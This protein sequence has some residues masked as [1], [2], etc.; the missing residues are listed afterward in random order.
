[1]HFEEVLERLGKECVALGRRRHPELGPAAAW[2]GWVTLRESY[3]LAVVPLDLAQRAIV[4]AELELQVRECAAWLW[5]ERK[6]RGLAH[7]MCLFLL[8]E[9]ERA[10]DLEAAKYYRHNV[11][12][13]L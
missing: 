3:M 4:Y 13:G 5:N 8:A 12:V 7:A 9:A 2:N 6:E 11:V 1:V 10:R